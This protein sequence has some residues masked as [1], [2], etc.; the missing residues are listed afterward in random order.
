MPA[1][2][3]SPRPSAKPILLGGLLA[4]LGDLI[5]AFTFYGRKLS[6]FQGVAGGLIGRDVARAGGV[7]TFLLGIALHFVIATIW[8]SLF[9]IASRRWPLL[10]KHAIPAGLV[11]GLVV[12]YGMNSIVLPLS[13]LHTDGWPPPVAPWP[14]AMHMLVVGLPIALV[15]RAFSSQPHL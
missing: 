9:W 5:F 7:P 12:F 13:A 2:I 10:V 4:G 14:M 1:P 6:V 11:Y 3:A 8:A 15:A